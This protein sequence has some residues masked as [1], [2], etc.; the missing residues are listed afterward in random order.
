MMI[1]VDIEGTPFKGRRSYLE[2]LGIFLLLGVTS[3]GGRWMAA[4]GEFRCAL[5]LC[6]DMDS[7]ETG[8]QRPR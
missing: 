8:A 2:A 4:R 1:T 7:V 3:F 6:Q 5:A